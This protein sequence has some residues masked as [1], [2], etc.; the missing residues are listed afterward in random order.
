MPD[1]TIVSEPVR[2]RVP[3]LQ[4]EEASGRRVVPIERLPF[5]IG[6][7][8]LSDLVLADPDVSRDHAE[9]IDDQGRFLLKDRSSRFGT[10]VNGHQITEHRLERNDR[11]AFGRGGRTELI[12]LP[13]DA[14]VISS[15]GASGLG[16][17]L[18]QIAVMFE[19]LRGM[20]SGRVLDEVLA[21]VLDSAIEVT[22]AERGFIMLA[23]SSGA[24]DMKL[25]RAAG[26]PFP[27]TSATMKPNA[28]EGRST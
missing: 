15:A 16:G 26:A 22:G 9:I 4:V 25:A 23:N 19:A 14:S 5:S 20:G 11:I 17:D 13:E 8:S 21:L 10:F 6:R 7:R 18:H 28:P 12:F 1:S 2:P 24:L 3:R 27:A